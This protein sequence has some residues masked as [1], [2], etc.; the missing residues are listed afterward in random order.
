MPTSRLLWTPRTSINPRGTGQFPAIRWPVWLELISRFRVRTRADLKIVNINEIDPGGTYYFRCWGIFS[1]DFG[2]YHGF[3]NEVLLIPIPHG[4]KNNNQHLIGL[5][6]AVVQETNRWLYHKQWRQQKEYLDINLLCHII[7]RQ[8]VSVRT[9]S[10]CVLGSWLDCRAIWIGKE[11]FKGGPSCAAIGNYREFADR[12]VR[13]STLQWRHNERDGVSNHQP[14]A[15]L[16]NRLFRS[17]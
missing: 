16:L 3:D 11:L 9:S 10:A 14:H 15:C 1:R 2:Q 7:N 5:Y 17:R 6:H 4:Q 13:G 12:F 8:S